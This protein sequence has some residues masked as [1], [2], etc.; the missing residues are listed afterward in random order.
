MLEMDDDLRLLIAHN[1]PIEGLRRQASGM[2]PLRT[3]GLARAADG[4]TTV[5]EVLRVCP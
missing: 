1:T 5:D 2:R 3:A 4:L